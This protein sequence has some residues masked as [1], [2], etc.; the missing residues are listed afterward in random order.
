MT[1][2][3]DDQVAERDGEFLVAF[4]REF[5]RTGEYATAGEAAAAT[6]FPKGVVDG[7]LSRLTISGDV[8]NRS[9]KRNRNTR[10]GPVTA[11]VTEYAPSPAKLRATILALEAST[12]LA[13]S[14]A[15]AAADRGALRMRV[16]RRKEPS[17]IHDGLMIDAVKLDLYGDTSDWRKI[18]TG[19]YLLVPIFDF[20]LKYRGPGFKVEDPRP[21]HRIEL[22]SFLEAGH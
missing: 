19:D 11:G 8:R 22:D 13:L 4:Q 5:I 9:G 12:R 3:T 18:P 1:R 15:D 20:E 2:P 7:A 10:R 14:A 6:R 16:T 17:P 21:G